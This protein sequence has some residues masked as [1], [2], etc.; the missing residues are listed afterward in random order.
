MLEGQGRCVSVHN[1]HTDNCGADI[2]QFQLVALLV[3]RLA[4]LHRYWLSSKFLSTTVT[5]LG[6]QDF[7][8][9]PDQSL[10]GFSQGVQAVH[11]AYVYLL[12]V[13]D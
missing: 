6:T 13:P 12:R 7:C 1:G 3:G 8:G 2:P 10:C 4:A 5:H 11:Q 9:P